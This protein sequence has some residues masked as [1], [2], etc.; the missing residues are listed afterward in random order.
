MKKTNAV[1]KV[2]ASLAYNE[3]KKGA[4][5]MCVWCFHQ[6]KLPEGVKKLRKF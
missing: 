5:T 1:E 3:A 6:P 4:N 2:V